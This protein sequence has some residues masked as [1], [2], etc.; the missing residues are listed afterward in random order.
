MTK[1][2]QVRVGDLGIRFVVLIVVVV[3][4]G[5]AVFEGV[6]QLGMGVTARLGFRGVTCHG[7]LGW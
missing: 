6:V 1:G 5:V 2:I 7:L 3:V 4:F